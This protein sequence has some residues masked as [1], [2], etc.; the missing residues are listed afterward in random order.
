MK[1]YNKLV[2]DLKTDN[3]IEEDSSEYKGPVIH[4]KGG[5]GTTTSVDEA[6]NRRMA[7]IAEAQQAMA[8]EYFNYYKYGRGGWSIPKPDMSRAA[9]QQEKEQGLLG[10][11]GYDDWVKE[12]H[13]KWLGSREWVPEEGAMGLQQLE[14]EQIIGASKLLPAQLS[15]A[16]EQIATQREY[17]KRARKGV[18]AEE[19]MGKAKTDVQQAYSGMGGEMRRGFGRMGIRPTSGRYAGMQSRMLREKAKSLAGAGT[20]GRRYAEEETLR[21]LSGMIGGR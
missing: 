2:Y 18:S 13:A 5:G 20:L 15:L 11:M 6:Y 19:E 9:Y 12:Q 17:L 7:A 21:R 8:E 1:I 16:G 10:K 14:Q 3:I 4:C